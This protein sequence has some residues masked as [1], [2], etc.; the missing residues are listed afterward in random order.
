M[1]YI[2]DT[3]VE[4]TTDLGSV[5]VVWDFRDVFP[6]ELARVPLERQVEFR[7]DLVAGSAPIAKAPYWLAPPKM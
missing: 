3:R 5:P 2:S 7:I 4:T 6:E 1:V